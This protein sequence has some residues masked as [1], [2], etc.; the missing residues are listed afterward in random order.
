MYKDFIGPP[1]P[2]EFIDLSTSEGVNLALHEASNATAWEARQKNIYREMLEKK[3]GYK[4]QL[5]ANHE[6]EMVPRSRSS[7]V[8]EV[9]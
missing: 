1:H 5:N 6:V 2:L 7:H 3:L 9:L 8:P 4:V